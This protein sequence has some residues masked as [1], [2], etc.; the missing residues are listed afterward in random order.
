MLWGGPSF[1]DEKG[2]GYTDCTGCC[3]VGVEVWGAEEDTLDRIN[4]YC[5]VPDPGWVF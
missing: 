4:K 2:D 3:C 1:E 5:S